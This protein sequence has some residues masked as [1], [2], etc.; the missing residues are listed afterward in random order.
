MQACAVACGNT[1]IITSG[2]P[3]RPSTT[4]I[5]TSLERLV[6]DAEPELGPLVLLEPQPEDYLGAV[7]PHAKRYGQPCYAP[8]AR[9]GSSPAAHRKRSAGR[10]LTMGRLPG[11][12][13]LQHPIS[14]AR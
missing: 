10:P 14:D 9:R 2:K 13:L 6:H 3:F 4:A 12:H 5:S 8:G 7:G 1:A 11:G